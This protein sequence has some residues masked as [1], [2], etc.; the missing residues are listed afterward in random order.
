MF[1]YFHFYFIEFEEWP[2]FIDC[3]LFHFQETSE[4]L[5]IEVTVVIKSSNHDLETNFPKSDFIFCNI[6]IVFEDINIR[7]H[8]L[9]KRRV[10]E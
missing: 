6:C 2:L 7:V 8:N 3:F 9:W 10:R 4:Y 1:V 5:C